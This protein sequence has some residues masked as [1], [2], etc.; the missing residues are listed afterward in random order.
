MILQ[1]RMSFNN[2]ELNFKTTSR[3]II[4]VIPEHRV[5]QG[6]VVVVRGGDADE[7]V[8]A[9]DP[10]PHRSQRSGSPYDQTPFAQ[11]RSRSVRSSTSAYFEAKKTG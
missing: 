8:P 10:R 9:Q 5:R 6:R 11:R 7:A 4:F 1:I 3:S 2:A